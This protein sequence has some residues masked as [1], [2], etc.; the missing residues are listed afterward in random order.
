MTIEVFSSIGQI[1]TSKWSDF[2]TK[3]FFLHHN[4]LHTMEKACTEIE[5]RYVLVSDSEGQIIAALYFQIL[6]FKGEHLFNY[7]PTNKA[8]LQTIFRASLSWIDTRLLVLGNVIFTCENGIQ[9]SSNIMESIPQIVSESIDKIV[10]NYPKKI[11]GTMLSETIAGMSND[12]FCKHGGFH[13]FQVEDRMEMEIGHYTHFEDYKSSLQSKYRVRLNKVYA[14]NSAIQ[15]Q[16]ITTH[17]FE[18]H[19]TEIQELFD[20]VMDHSKFKMNRL[21][22]EYFCQF[23]RNIDRFHMLAYFHNSKMVAFVTY[24]SLDTIIEVHYIGLDYANNLNHKTYN[25][26]LYDMLQMAIEEKKKNICFGRT[27]QEL[28]ST[29]GAKPYSVFSSLKVNHKLLN[30]CTPFFLSKLLPAPWI[31]R[32][33]FKNP[34]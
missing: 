15:K 25:F 14:L 34:T 18:N 12:F 29:I 4:Y 3:R 10:S 6:P 24:F 33:P 28:K 23:V 26:I 31:M 16:V 5:F 9:I 1:Q 20:Q 2:V 11:L 8:W 13:S 7:I 30:A 22:A 17:N 27:A 32:S 19:R 21:T